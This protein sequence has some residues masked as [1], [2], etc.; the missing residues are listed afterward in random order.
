MKT[1]GRRASF[2]IAKEDVRG[3]AQVPDFWIGWATITDPDDIVEYVEDSASVGRIE[4][5]DGASIIR[6]HGALGWS[7]KI[8]HDHFGLVLLSFAGT[9]TPVARGSPNTAVIDHTIS[10]AQTVTHQSLSLTL[11]DPN[12][13]Y[14]FPNAV[15]NTIDINCDPGNY[16]MYTATTLSKESESISSTPALTDIKDW[17]PQMVTF[18]HAANQAALDAASAVVIRSFSIQLAANAIVEE[19]LGSVGPVDVLNQTVRIS[20]TITKTYTDETFKTYQDDNTFRALRFDIN[21]TETIGTNAHP[22][23]KIDLHQV[24]FSEWKKDMNQNGILT[25]SMNFTAMLSYADAKMA[26]IVLSN[27]ITAY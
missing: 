6:K 14:C 1:I 24:Y 5:I 4:E 13:D 17:V 2:G 15:V 27:L 18:K 25:E 22:E 16:I 10:I 11:K 26:T 3:T 19:G 21:G 20:G 12:V 23:L 9:D 8:K 7:A